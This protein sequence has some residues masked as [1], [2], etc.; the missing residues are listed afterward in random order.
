MQVSSC[1]EQVSENDRHQRFS[2]S[3]RKS[4]ES[5]S[6][7]LETNISTFMRQLKSTRV[8]DIKNN[9]E[10]FGDLLV[11]F[12]ATFNTDMERLVDVIL[13]EKAASINMASLR[14]KLTKLVKDE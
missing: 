1:T 14:S 12:A 5:R 9:A 13:G 11:S 4:A 8:D 7:S 6:K 3:E 2:D 10:I